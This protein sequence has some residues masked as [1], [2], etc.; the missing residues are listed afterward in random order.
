LGSAGSEEAAEQ[1][2]GATNVKNLV[3]ALAVCAALAAMIDSALDAGPLPPVRNQTCTRFLWPWSDFDR[4]EVGGYEWQ[5][6]ETFGRRNTRPLFLDSL[7]PRRC[8]A[9]VYD[10]NVLPE[11]PLAL[12]VLIDSGRIAGRW[13]TPLP[14]SR[15]ECELLPRETVSLGGYHHWKDCR[16]LFEPCWAA[17]P[18]S[19]PR[20]A[21][22]ATI[23]HVPTSRG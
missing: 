8:L 2:I 15:P 22:A 23:R 10:D 4:I 9:F 14:F 21:P 7:E 16:P 18:T 13:L 19:R 11:P 6:Y 17:D 20:A 3:A 1:G 12:T 5:A